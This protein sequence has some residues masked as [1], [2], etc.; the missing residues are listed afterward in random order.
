MNKLKEI[1]GKYYQECNVVIIPTNRIY[2]QF[3]PELKDHYTIV[4]HNLKELYITNL[5]WSKKYSREIHLYIV[6][7]EE[8]KEGDWC[9][10]MNRD[11]KYS[12]PFQCNKSKAFVN[13]EF[14]NS[15]DDVRKII[16]TTDS[17]LKLNEECIK[18]NG[19]GGDQSGYCNECSGTGNPK[20]LPQPS[21]QFI[22]KYIEEFNKGNK[23]EKILVEYTESC[24]NCATEGEDCG[25]FKTD[26][27]SCITIKPIKDSWTRE[28]TKNL[29]LKLSKF[30]GDHH[31]Y[32]EVNKWI[33]E[34]L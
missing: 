27:H 16:A 2:T 6:S 9:I 15:Q 29:L 4:R 28:E 7:D 23:I 5:P 11:T 3:D 12:K 24:I 22:Q 18:C 17:S 14:L 13:P 25:T 20:L 30:K 33:E 31:D 1:N 26:S 10:A 32:K 21:K 8:I 34:N 19:Y